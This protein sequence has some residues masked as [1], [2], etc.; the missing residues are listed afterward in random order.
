M[1]ETSKLEQITQKIIDVLKADT[2]LS[3][4]NY[5]FGPPFT[6]ETP[7]CYVKWVGGPI[8]QETFQSRLWR[9]RW[10]VVIIDSA[11]TD[12]VAEKSVMDKIERAYEVLKANPTLDGIVRDSRP[13][14]M[15][16]ETVTIGVEWGK[17]QL[18]LAAARLVL[19]V[20]VEWSD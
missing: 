7:F 19:E 18:I 2:E 10:H 15:A 17:V 8:I 3:G 11:K 13:V 5:Y 6:R 9:F 1:S 14:E 12:D 4:L 20:D 16:G